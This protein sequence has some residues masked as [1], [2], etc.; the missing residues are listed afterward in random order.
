[1]LKKEGN[2]WCILQKDALEVAKKLGLDKD[3]YSYYPT[4]RVFL[5]DI[6]WGFEC[7]PCC[8]NCKCNT[9]VDVHGFRDNHPGR[10][11]VGKTTCTL[12]KSLRVDQEVVAPEAVL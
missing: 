7:M 12:A 11:V 6:Q 4:V 5:P 8:P 3:H 10:I 9:R 2:G 1:M